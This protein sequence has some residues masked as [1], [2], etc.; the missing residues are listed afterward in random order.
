MKEKDR[1][2]SE[3]CRSVPDQ[4]PGVTKGHEA[5][6][7]TQTVGVDSLTTAGCNSV[8]HFRKNTHAECGSDLK[9]IKTI[10]FEEQREVVNMT[11]GVVTVFHRR[12]L[13]DRTV[14]VQMI[15]L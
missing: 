10:W 13:F 11:M 5:S 15:I 6:E 1:L 3:P 14:F 12:G 9:R 8:A 2:Q 4:A 7:R